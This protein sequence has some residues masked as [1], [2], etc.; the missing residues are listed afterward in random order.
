MPLSPQSMEPGQMRARSEERWEPIDQAQKP[1]LAAVK[2]PPVW[3]C[4]MREGETHPALACR[5]RRWWG[6]G[7]KV[8][9]RLSFTPHTERTYPFH[10]AKEYSIGL[11][12]WQGSG[13]TLDA[14]FR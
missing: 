3:I 7:Q 13:R 10:P 1:T 4:R 8:S 12:L 14:C 11:S 6:Q 9:H 5:N 2:T